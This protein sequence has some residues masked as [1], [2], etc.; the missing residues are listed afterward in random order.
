M[1]RRTN[2]ISTWLD[3]PDHLWSSSGGQS[4][5]I[6][7]D[8]VHSRGR[9]KISTG[10]ASLRGKKTHQKKRTIL[11]CKVKHSQLLQNA[12]AV[13]TNLSFSFASLRERKGAFWTITLH[14]LHVS[15]LRIDNPSAF[16]LPPLLCIVWIQAKC[17]QITM[18]GE[19]SPHK[20]W[21]QMQQSDFFLYSRCRLKFNGRCKLGQKDGKS[22]RLS[23]FMILFSKVYCDH[24]HGVT[25][26]SLFFTL[27][28]PR[29]CWVV[30]SDEKKVHQITHKL[31]FVV[32]PPPNFFS[33]FSTMW[34]GFS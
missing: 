16:P 1:L 10:S 4:D 21:E 34:H 27:W 28:L 8:R 18:Q 26:K 11:I 24:N 17:G 33:R 7:S 20:D 22:G 3:Q 6:A 15:L 31:L 30:L 12:I 29:R 2:S 32:F 5:R 23:V 19:C 13:K 25:F 14:H 9:N